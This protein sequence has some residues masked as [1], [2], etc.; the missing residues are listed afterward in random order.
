MTSE[1]A[2]PIDDLEQLPLTP[3]TQKVNVADAYDLQNRAKT[4]EQELS[5]ARTKLTREIRKNRWLQLL[6]H[7]Y[8]EALARAVQD[9]SVLR[10][11]F[12][13]V[14]SSHLALSQEFQKARVM[15]ETL[16]AVIRTLSGSSFEESASR[17]TVVSG[18]QPAVDSGDC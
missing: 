7:E 8:M 17:N 14:S 9:Y 2:V 18:G 10:H 5:I 16:D 12:D 1:V 3:A 6:N 13:L 11:N 15:V 4:A